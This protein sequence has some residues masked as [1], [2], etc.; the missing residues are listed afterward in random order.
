M[1]LVKSFPNQHMNGN[2]WMVLVGLLAVLVRSDL[3]GEAELLVLRHENHV[4]R[5]Q[6]GG[7]PRWDH[8]DRLWL[9]ALSRLVHRCRWVE[10]FPLA[11]ATILRWHRNL[12][13]CKWIF[14]DRR[15]RGDAPTGQGTDRAHGVGEPDL[16]ASADP[17]RVGPPGLYGRGL[18]GVRDPARGR[19]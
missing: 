18:H 10:V 12:V 2:G 9:A 16:G 15:R 13:A 7:Q 17:R 1:Q 14:A 11:P 5:R 6:L 8:A 4:L 3:S 19:Y